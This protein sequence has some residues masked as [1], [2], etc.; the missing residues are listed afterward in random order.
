MTHELTEKALMD[1][2]VEDDVAHAAALETHP[3]G[4]NYDPDV[5]NNRFFN[6]NAYGEAWGGAWLE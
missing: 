1:K 2:G 5:L 6:R 3:F 4:E